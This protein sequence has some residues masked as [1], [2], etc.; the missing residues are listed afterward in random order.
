MNKN[1][2]PQINEN[3]FNVVNRH[4]QRAPVKISAIAQELGV[5]VLAATLPAGISGELRPENHSY[6]IRVNRHDS[7]GRQ[8]FTVAHE[9]AHFLLHKNQIGSGITDDVLYRSKLNDAREAEANRLA[10]E[11][12]MPKEILTT[13]FR[14]SILELENKI[15]EL[16]DQFQVSKAAVRIRL[17]NLYLI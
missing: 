17:G 5:N 2:W 16:A 14:S 4:I 10:A 12:I 6:L 15:S 3:E 13:A 7:K 11:I 1:E 9:I 8:R